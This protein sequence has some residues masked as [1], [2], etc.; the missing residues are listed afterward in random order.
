V[1]PKFS[2]NRRKG[3]GNEPSAVLVETIV[4]SGEASG[5]VVSSYNHQLRPAISDRNRGSV[6]TIRVTYIDGVF[7]L[8]FSSRTRTIPFEWS[9]YWSSCYFPRFP[10]ER[11]VELWIFDFTVGE[12]QAIVRHMDQEIGQFQRGSFPATSNISFI[13]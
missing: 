8:T 5:V 9:R 3:L 11:G 7:L 2:S 13:P 1:S 10:N 12:G 4:T 6:T